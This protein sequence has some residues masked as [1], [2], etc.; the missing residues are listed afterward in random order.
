[1]HI[2]RQSYRPERRFGRPVPRIRQREKKQQD[3][4]GNESRSPRALVLPRSV[5]W[6]NYLYLNGSQIQPQQNPGH[7]LFPPLLLLF[8]CVVFFL[9]HCRRYC[10]AYFTRLAFPFAL[11]PFL[12]AFPPFSSS[13]LY[14]P[15]SSASPPL[16]HYHLSPLSTVHSPPIS[17]FDNP[18]AE[19]SNSS[20]R[21]ARRD[22]EE[23]VRGFDHYSLL[24]LLLLLLHHHHSS[25][26]PPLLPFLPL[27]VDSTKEPSARA[28]ED[29]AGYG[30][31][32]HRQEGQE[33]EE[34]E[35]EEDRWHYT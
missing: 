11:R 29:A 18:P 8:L 25:L 31:G 19:G 21:H 35:G 7:H 22:T 32:P 10:R 3:T 26:P 1:M 14:T 16:H 17:A 9:C 5:I 34:E 4:R 27:L 23:V 13:Y 12:S 24:L 30:R 33:E 15:T 28:Q 2:N 6:I 20:T